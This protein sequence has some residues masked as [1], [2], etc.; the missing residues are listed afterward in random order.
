MKSQ[1][2]TNRAPRPYKNKQTGMKRSAGGG[3]FIPSAK[4]SPRAVKKNNGGPSTDQP[5][6]RQD[7]VSLIGSI[8]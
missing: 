7:G 2:Q 8:H 3:G 4:P 1:K 6:P 5:A